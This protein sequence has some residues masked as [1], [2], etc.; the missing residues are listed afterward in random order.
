MT[1][2]QFLGSRA[3]DGI[4]GSVFAFHVANLGLIHG[5][6]VQWALQKWS[7]ST[8]TGVWAQNIPEHF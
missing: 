8:E 5:R 2:K 6:K 3:R 7:I 4:V 1:E